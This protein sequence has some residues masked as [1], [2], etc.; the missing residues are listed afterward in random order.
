MQK[1]SF[2]RIVIAVLFFC[3]F[4]SVN[5]SQAVL[6]AQDKVILFEN[7]IRIYDSSVIFVPYSDRCNGGI[8]SIG[9]QFYPATLYK[10]NINNPLT[11]A[12]FDKQHPYKGGLDSKAANEW[13]TKV[14]ADYVKYL[15]E[16]TSRSATFNPG[17]S[18]GGIGGTLPGSRDVSWDNGTIGTSRAHASFYSN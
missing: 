1:S 14:E 8:C 7:G 6:F 4:L 11:A 16:N 3:S 5:V 9:Q 13:Y 2:H 12:D 10:T 17:P 15:Q 18:D